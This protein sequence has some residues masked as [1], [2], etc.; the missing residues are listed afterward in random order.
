MNK[1][2]VIATLR[3]DLSLSEAFQTFLAGFD[4]DDN[5]WFARH[6]GDFFLSEFGS[7]WNS[8]FKEIAQ[9][10]SDDYFRTIGL[11][12][13]DLPKV[14]L[15]DSRPGS[16]IMEAALTMFGTVG[17]A[18]TILKA[19]ADLPKIA[20]G[21]EDA[22]KRLSQELKSRFKVRVPQQI[23]PVLSNRSAPTPLPPAVR[24][25][26]TSVAC[27]IDARPLRALTPDVAKAHSIHLSV[28]VSRSALSVENLGDSAIENVQIGLFKSSTQ[29]HSWSFG[30]AYSRSI[31]RLGA[32]QS[33][34]LNISD[35]TLESAG[36]KLDL[37][38]GFALHVDCWI[39][40]KSGI[41]LFNFF[42]E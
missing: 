34:C 1:E 15:T 30:D 23:E 17:T 2:T 25:N 9:S 42:L 20:D 39:Q 28:A 22:K 6:G 38:D 31:P 10:V 14:T 41:Y 26:P 19:V 18:Y 21:L 40:D 35:F 33:L 8:N 11:S 3:A 29:R 4:G 32:K 37:S 27:S 13:E 7:E 12:E 24:A 16:W 36:A 5:A